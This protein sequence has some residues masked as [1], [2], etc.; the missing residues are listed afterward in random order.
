MLISL[1]CLL[2]LSRSVSASMRAL[3]RSIATEPAVLPSGTA[4]ILA[5][6]SCSLPSRAASQRRW[7]SFS[8]ARISSSGACFISAA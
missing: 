1:G 3:I 7:L 4:S 5:I 8:I 6:K 2:P